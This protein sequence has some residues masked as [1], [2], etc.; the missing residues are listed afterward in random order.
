[1]EEASSSPPSSPPEA[2]EDAATCKRSHEEMN[3]DSE[4]VR[5]SSTTDVDEVEVCAPKLRNIDSSSTMEPSSAAHTMLPP[6]APASTMLPPSQKPPRS[7]QGSQH[8]QKLQSQG[9]EAAHG[10]AEKQNQ[11]A[12][13]DETT[14]DDTG[15]CFDSD[16]GEPQDK[17][18]DFDWNDLQHRYHDKITEVN[19]TERRIMEEFNGLC[20]ASFPYPYSFYLTDLLQYFSVWAQTGSA[21]EVDRSFKRY[22]VLLPGVSQ[23]D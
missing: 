21:H 8:T 1:M 4:D 2:K 12:S 10:T 7:G 13:T 22:A 9:D 5:E 15:S 16:P 18:E 14:S 20:D 19:D 23:S 3:V 11:A 17:I 6:S